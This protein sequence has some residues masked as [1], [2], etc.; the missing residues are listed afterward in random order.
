VGCIRLSF[1]IALLV[2]APASAFAYIL[3]P[4][5]NI[6]IEVRTE[7]TVISLPTQVSV[8]GRVYVAPA[9]SF[10]AQG[11]TPAELEADIAQGLSKYYVGHVQATVLVMQPKQLPVSVLG[12]VRQ[13]GDYRIP[14]DR[15]LLSA[16]ITKAGGPLPQASM[17]RVSLTRAGKELGPIDLYAI[18][19][20]G[21][22]DQD[23]LLRP[24][25]VIYVPARE[26]WATVIGPAE[27]AGIYELLPGDRLSNI[28]RM[29][30]GLTAAADPRQ[31]VIERSQAQGNPIIIKVNIE[32]ALANPG[33]DADPLLEHG[34]TVRLATRLA[35]VYVVGEVAQPGPREFQD[36][37]TLLDYIGLS[38]GVTNRAVQSRV[39]IFRPG[40]PESRMITVDLA[41]VMAKPT[42]APAIAPGDIILVPERRI[43]TLQDWASIGQILT[44]IF[45]GIRLF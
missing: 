3:G 6:S 29:A 41:R 28:I 4:G 7:Q 20:L 9:G 33:G 27:Q 39:G 1:V 42:G 36:N 34:D 30:G 15:P 17:R 45:A 8:E 5:D 14:D 26:R 43:A 2:L 18:L 10:V 40:S 44:G 31:A 35:Q 32:A 37:R 11:K 13:P 16:A 22:S 12:Q 38:G 19:N 21:R 23:V 24:E 25:D